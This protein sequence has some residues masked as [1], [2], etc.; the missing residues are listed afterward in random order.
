MSDGIVQIA[1][2]RSGK[3]IDTSE[4]T[5]GANTVERQRVVIGDN[6][7]ATALAT[8]K[9]GSTPA[10]AADNALVVAVSPG[11]SVTLMD[12]TTAITGGPVVAA[13]T[14]LFQADTTD[15]NSIAVQLNGAW[16]GAIVFQTSNDAATWFPLWGWT[17]NNDVAPIDRVIGPDLITLPN[18]GRYFRAI[19]DPTFT[20]SVSW[21]AYQRQ[22]EVELF[23]T[24]QVTFDPMVPVPMGGRTS[25]GVQ[26]SVLTDAQ[27]AIRTADMA[28]PF[29]GVGAVTGQV[30][31]LL[32]TSGYQSI[33]VQITAG[34]ST[35]QF[36]GSN[37]GSVWVAALGYNI[38]SGATAPVASIAIG[39]LWVFPCISRYF[40][41]RLSAYASATAITAYL[42]SQPAPANGVNVVSV[43]GSQV[44]QS[45]GVL[46]VNIA[47]VAGANTT[48]AGT[49]AVGG[50]AQVGAISAS[51][52]VVTAGVDGSGLVRRILTD[53]KGAQVIVG[54]DPSVNLV[55]NPFLVTQAPGTF[56]GDGVI[57]TLNTI[58]RE[59]RLLNI[60]ISELP[61]RLINSIPDNDDDRLFREDMT[62]FV[63]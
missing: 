17:A 51:Y 43:G 29:T 57:D 45:S 36:E 14:Q 59:L 23:P 13:S 44:S 34:T 24:Q 35:V 42:R 31:I 60:K 58:A 10:T 30:P 61:L 55:P 27:G 32:D 2:D 26:T 63:N 4:I 62:N 41:C 9:D 25:A 1:P 6:T 40:R 12:A 16:T 8:V 5:V 47:T 39:S 28:G 48:T 33:S 53:S 38:S 54:T 22:Q 18:E 19:T 20:G 37:D 21:V 46:A 52:P 15:Y 50:P 56:A 7:S 11:T 3:K 49:L